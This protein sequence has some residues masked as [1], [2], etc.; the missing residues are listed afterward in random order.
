VP[1]VV[2][3]CRKIKVGS[4]S[5]PTVVFKET[6]QQTTVAAWRTC[7]G[8]IS[9]PIDQPGSRQKLFSPATWKVIGRTQFARRFD[10]SVIGRN[11]LCKIRFDAR[12]TIKFESARVS[13]FKM[14]Q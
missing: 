9:A 6:A 10:F 1:V 7:H 3:A 13:E 5:A 11:F 4:E 14:L 8:I 12:L 2:P